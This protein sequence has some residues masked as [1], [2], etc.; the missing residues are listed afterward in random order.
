V[1]AR[2]YLK[3]RARKHDISYNCGGSCAR[4]P[5]KFSRVSTR[6]NIYENPPV[7]YVTWQFV[8]RRCSVK[9]NKSTASKLVTFRL[10]TTQPTTRWRTTS[11]HHQRR[12][13]TTST[14]SCRPSDQST[15]SPGSPWPRGQF[16]D[17]RST[18]VITAGSTGAC[19]AP[20]HVFVLQGPVLPLHTCLLYMGLCCPC[21]GRRFNLI[22]DLAANQIVDAVSLQR[23]A[24]GPPAATDAP[25]S[26]RGLFAAIEATPPAFRDIFSE[27][28]SVASA[29]GGLPAVLEQLVRTSS[30]GY[31]AGRDMASLRTSP[32]SCG[33]RRLHAALGYE[34]GRDMASLRPSPPSCGPRL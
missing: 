16:I 21:P 4:N 5:P 13:R 22:V 24:A 34:A 17:S 1:F 14:S 29:A 32:P 23:F 3:R 9:V 7:L 19:A 11:R 20:A 2:L 30:L 6:I 8:L 27:F 25:P 26:S 28:Q 12:R 15:P 33:P 10:T 18:V 31:E